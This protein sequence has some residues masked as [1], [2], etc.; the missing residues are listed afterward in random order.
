M[1]GYNCQQSPIL[2]CVLWCMTS[3]GGVTVYVYVSSLDMRTG[4]AHTS[5]CQCGVS[6]LCVAVYAGDRGWVISNL[7]VDCGLVLAGV[8]ESVC[9]LLD[10]GPRDH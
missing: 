9:V 10:T 7:T 1:Y 3:V 5:L 8:L 4:C 6:C 2:L